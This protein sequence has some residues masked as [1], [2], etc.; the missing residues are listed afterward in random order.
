MAVL[1]M[2]AARG[3]RALPPGLGE[4][5]CRRHAGAPA[6][7][8]LP[9]SGLNK[10]P[11]AWIPRA[12][13]SPWS[14]RCCRWLGVRL[15]QRAEMVLQCGLHASKSETDCL[16][17]RGQQCSDACGSDT[18]SRR[19]THCP[20]SIGHQRLSQL[21]CWASQLISGG[22]S[23]AV[24]RVFAAVRQVASGAGKSEPLLSR[25]GMVRFR[26]R[27]STCNTS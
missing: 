22:G 21:A 5:C 26:R 1:W 2:P 8:L 7:G 16:F 12:I 20:S 14:F 13:Q 17:D 24:G 10:S 6:H 15:V 19:D 18:F 11:F 27:R 4:L 9:R 23:A 3:R 25:F